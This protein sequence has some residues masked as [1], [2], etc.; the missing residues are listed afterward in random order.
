MWSE[1]GNEP[2]SQRLCCLHNSWQSQNRREGTKWKKLMVCLEGTSGVRVWRTRRCG[3]DVLGIKQ[4]TSSACRERCHPLPP[5]AGCIRRP[6]QQSIWEP[7]CTKRVL[8]SNQIGWKEKGETHGPSWFLLVWAIH[9]WLTRSGILNKP[10]TSW[11]AEKLQSGTRRQPWT[12]K[13]LEKAFLKSKRTP[14]FASMK[15]T[16]RWECW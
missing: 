2:N 6:W 1:C 14:R 3:G 8:K 9:L 10:C 12:A 4:S 11:M 15:V 5:H 7:R 16:G 13:K